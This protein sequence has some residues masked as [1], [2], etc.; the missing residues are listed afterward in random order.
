[1]SQTMQ[2][3]AQSQANPPK[4]KENVQHPYHVG[5]TSKTLG[6]RCTCHTN[7]LCSL[8]TSHSASRQARVCKQTHLPREK[9][10]RDKADLTLDDE[11][12]RHKWLF[13]DA[14]NG[15]FLIFTL[16]RFCLCRHITCPPLYLIKYIFDHISQFSL[17]PGVVFWG[18]PRA[19]S[20]PSAHLRM[21]D[22]ERNGWYLWLIFWEFPPQAHSSPPVKLCCA[23]CWVFTPP[24]TPSAVL[25]VP[26]WLG[27][28][29]PLPWPG[30]ISPCLPYW[31]QYSMYK[32]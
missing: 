17:R 29:F 1:M 28:I 30:Y 20:S 27:Y 13:S 25:S 9:R 6:R 11:S 5:P 24:P 16:Q 21:H 3:S 4:T 22:H 7:V 12:C 32:I 15:Q 18:F 26:L 23:E 2:I 10:R 8:G 31:P 19:E 14:L